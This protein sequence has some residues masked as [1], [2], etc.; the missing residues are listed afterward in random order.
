[1]E[2]NVNCIVCGE[3]ASIVLPLFGGDGEVKKLI[4]F[5]QYELEQILNYGSAYLKA[6][7]AGEHPIMGKIVG[8]VLT[9]EP[10]GYKVQIMKSGE[11]GGEGV[12][13]VV[14]AVIQD[15]KSDNKRVIIAT[16]GNK[17]YDKMIKNVKVIA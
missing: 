10:I 11:T 7:F 2:S 8:K 12:E 15:A 1:M 3:K 14:I 9:D 13:G 5:H 6:L 4:G 17:T 16:P